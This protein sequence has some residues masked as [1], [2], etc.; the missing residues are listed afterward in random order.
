LV[1]LNFI[2]YKGGEVT[3]TPLLLTSEEAFGAP[4]IGIL[5]Y[6]LPPVEFKPYY[7]SYWRT[8]YPRAA[9]K[10]WSC[11]GFPPS[12][13]PTN[14]YID[15]HWND[16]AN[17][18]PDGSCRSSYY[19]RGDR[20]LCFNYL[21]GNYDYGNGEYT[22]F[23]YTCGNGGILNPA[24]KYCEAG[25]NGNCYSNSNCNAAAGLYCAKVG[26]QGQTYNPGVC[27]IAGEPNNYGA[28]GGGFAYC[29]P[30]APCAYNLDIAA[31]YSSVCIDTTNALSC[32]LYPDGSAKYGPG[33]QWHWYP[34]TAFY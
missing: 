24:T 23:A 14:S 26:P 1:D 11:S 34:Y 7:D 19:D 17:S 28:C 2:I 5:P 21:C 8:C 27:C 33:A 13:I 16:G 6:L 4:T 25:R 10:G 31:Y 30:P 20:N 18:D 32:L 15:I 9:A 29:E 12:Q 3:G 22:S